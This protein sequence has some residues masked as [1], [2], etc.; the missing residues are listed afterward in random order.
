MFKLQA[1]LFVIFAI[2]P[3]YTF[4]QSQVDAQIAKEEAEYERDWYQSCLY[5]A[6]TEHEAA[7]DS[8]VA[9]KN[10][11]RA[12]QVAWPNDYEHVDE[13]WL[14]YSDD[15]DLL[16]ISGQGLRQDGVDKKATADQTFT[17][18]ETAYA[19]QDWDVAFMLFTSAK[20][21]YFDAGTDVDLAYQ[22]FMSARDAFDLAKEQVLYWNQF[23]TDIN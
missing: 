3:I 7:Y 1:I 4:G 11:E 19:N 8:F 17:Y 12:I 2:S 9:F 20:E 18:A 6:N 23:F 13:Y 15:G 5:F 10:A 21:D 14:D 22:H 16:V